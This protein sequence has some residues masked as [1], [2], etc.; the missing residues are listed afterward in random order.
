M[1]KDSTPRAKVEG[2]GEAMLPSEI[3]LQQQRGARVEKISPEPQCGDWVL[4]PP[5]PSRGSA[6]VAKEV[7]VDQVWGSWNFQIPVLQLYGGSSLPF[8][9]P[10]GAS[11]GGRGGGE[12]P[13][14]QDTR[15]PPGWDG[16]LWPQSRGRLCPEALI[17]PDLVEADHSLLLENV[18]PCLL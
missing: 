5:E 13:H 14:G 2:Q 3:P 6:P 1:S 12:L 4:E 18:A 9:G 7:G 17:L 15:K 8:P 11:C 16:S 10:S